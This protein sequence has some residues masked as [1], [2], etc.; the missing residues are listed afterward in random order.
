LAVVVPAG[1]A[2]ASWGDVTCPAGWQTVSYSPGVTA[3]SQ[4]VTVTYELDL[5]ICVS[6]SN[7]AVTSGFS[8]G[9]VTVALSCAD[10]LGTTTGTQD[11]TWNTGQSS[12]LSFVRTV[13]KVNGQTVIT[14]AGT[15]S[16]GLFAGNAAV[17]T[18]IEPTLDLLACQS[19]EGLE[20]NEGVSTFVVL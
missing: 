2:S 19:P 7:P 9:T 18:V 6:L 8:G 13:T 20:S 3:V 1:P 16:S 15:I 11:F 12:T 10:L 5:G 4:P 17:L 14:L